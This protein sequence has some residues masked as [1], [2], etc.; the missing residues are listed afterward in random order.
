[1]PHLQLSL[2]LDVLVRYHQSCLLMHSECCQLKPSVRSGERQCWHGLVLSQYSYL[3]TAIDTREVRHRRFVELTH[4][5]P[6]LYSANAI[7]GRRLRDTQG[8]PEIRQYVRLSRQ[9]ASCPPL[10]VS[11]SHCH[12]SFA[13]WKKWSCKTGTMATR[14]PQHPVR[15]RLL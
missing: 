14:I 5:A 8:H 11:L 7:G 3:V 1:M 6:C 13:V 15:N 9:L 2:T 10:C 4:S 12:V